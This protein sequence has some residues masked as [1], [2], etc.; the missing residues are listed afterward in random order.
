M[1]SPALR[2]RTALAIGAATAPLVVALLMTP[3]GH[4]SGTDCQLPASPVT[5]G[6]GIEARSVSAQVMRGG[7][8]D[9]AIW[10]RAPRHAPERRGPLS[11][12]VVIDRSGSMTGEPIER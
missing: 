9:V 2:T 1:A 6:V 10:I 5:G 12:A 11:L 7:E 3:R 4:K 8:Q